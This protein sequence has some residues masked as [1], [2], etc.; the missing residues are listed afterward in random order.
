MNCRVALDL[1]P[2]ESFLNGSSS[3]PLVTCISISCVVDV[4]LCLLIACD[5][6]GSGSGYLSTIASL[7]LG[8]P[9]QKRGGKLVPKSGAPYE[10]YGM[11]TMLCSLS[12]G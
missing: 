7:L 9:L 2:G 11:K 4:M 12:P 10:N 6:V 1:R 3:L 8:P 5:I